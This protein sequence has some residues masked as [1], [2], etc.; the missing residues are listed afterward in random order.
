MNQEFC[1]DMLC[2]RYA[3]DIQ[4]AGKHMSLDI[5]A[6]DNFFWVINV[7]VKAMRLDELILVENKEDNGR[8][9]IEKVSRIEENKAKT[10]D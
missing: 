3:L 1:F 8:S 5:G 4:E 6:G 10:M 7:V 9:R 2:L